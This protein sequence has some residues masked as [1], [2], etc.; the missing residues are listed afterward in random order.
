MEL[1]HFLCFL[2]VKETEEQMKG[3]FH[4]LSFL[5]ESDFSKIQ[6]LFPLS[7]FPLPGLPHYLL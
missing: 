7:V 1:K 3:M 5:Q 6:L 2:N 4:V